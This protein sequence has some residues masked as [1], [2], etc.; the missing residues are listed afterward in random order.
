[1]A[2]NV[3]RGTKRKAIGITL[4][5]LGTAGIIYAGAL[6]F[7][8]GMDRHPAAGMLLLSIVIVFSGIAQ[9]YKNEA[10]EQ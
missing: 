6:Q 1:M 8:E 2:T 9:L 4:T 3:K 10:D 5:I 7:A